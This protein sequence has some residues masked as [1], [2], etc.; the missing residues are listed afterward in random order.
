MT[1]FIF[2]LKRCLRSPANLLLLCGLPVAVVLL[3]RSQWQALPIGYQYYG[4]LL[5]FA[6]SKLVHMLMEDRRNKMMNRIGAAP[7]THLHYLLQHL[8]AFGLLLMIQCAVVAGGGMLVHGSSLRLAGQLFLVYSVFAVTAISFSLAW[9]SLFRHPESS[10]AVM[11]GIIM[12]MAMLGGV[13]V[14]IEYLPGLLQRLALAV[15]LYWLTLGT[16]QAAQGEALGELL[17]PLWM[18]VMFSAA[19]LLI[20]SRRKLA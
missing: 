15:P 5:L 11:L 16:E 14:P 8:L 4:V 10:I 2:V 12:V 1:I 20:G 6:A 3:P 13:F 17:M 19:F 18:L 7:V 9:C